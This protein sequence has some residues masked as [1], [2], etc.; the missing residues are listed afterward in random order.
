MGWVPSPSHFIL[1]R[2]Y[3]VGTII[4]HIVQRSKLRPGVT[5][6]KWQEWDPILDDLTLQSALFTTTLGCLLQQCGRVLIWMFTLSW[7]HL[8]M[9]FN[10]SCKNDAVILFYIL[11]FVGLETLM[12]QELQSWGQAVAPHR[13]RCFPPSPPA[14]AWSPSPRSH[15]E[16]AFGGH[17][18]WVPPQH[19]GFP[20]YTNCLESLLL[21]GCRD[22]SFILKSFI[23]LIINT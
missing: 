18:D 15:P 16:L 2:P 14:W 8:T 1:T 4:I 6:Y 3:A 13:V 10:Y 23:H 11:K 5:Q 20:G 7:H 19:Q 21:L 17:K 9:E 12:A 22:F